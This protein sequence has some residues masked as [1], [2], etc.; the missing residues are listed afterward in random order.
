[1]KV[2]WWVTM[3]KGSNLDEQHM[4]ENC[5]NGKWKSN[6][7]NLEQRLDISTIFFY[8]HVR[9]NTTNKNQINVLTT[10]AGKTKVNFDVTKV[11]T[12]L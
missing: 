12:N 5:W 8:F 7:A 4:Y 11:S 2:E 6:V 9:K 1:M 3:K 10:H